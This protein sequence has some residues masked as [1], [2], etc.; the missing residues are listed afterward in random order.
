VSFDL[1]GSSGP[2]SG[3]FDGPGGSRLQVDAQRPGVGASL[4]PHFLVLTLGRTR[5]VVVVVSH[6]SGGVWRFVPARGSAVRSIRR[7]LGLPSPQI[8][9]AVTGS[10]LRR[11]LRWSIADIPGQRVTFVQR[12]PAVD[13]VLASNLSAGL[14]QR[15]FVEA[16][17]AGGSRSIEAIVTEGG[18]VRTSVEVARFNTAPVLGVHIEVNDVAGGHGFV[19]QGVNGSACAASC[20]MTLLGTSTV[21]L[22]AT[23]D[24]GS[25]F[26]DWSVRSCGT[27][28]ACV[29]KVDHYLAVT[30]SFARVGKVSASSTLK[31]A[32]TR[33]NST[34]FRTRE[35]RWPVASII[36]ASSRDLPQAS[37]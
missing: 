20:S 1:S 15:A 5:S 3:V 33:P 12:G 10:G 7:A 11:V 27:A 29:L 23:P 21:H 4:D 34:L 9:A 28:R 6:P 26:L 13:Q 14:G 35:A 36:R 18:L 17:G 30:A 8:R 2:P 31:M 16:D 19:T 37:A 22:T 24:V 32:S 25:R